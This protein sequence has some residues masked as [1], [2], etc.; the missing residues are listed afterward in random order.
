MPLTIVGQPHEADGSGYYRF[1]L[2]FKHLA[3]SS[4]HRVL[5]PEPGTKFTPSD[6]EIAQTDLIVGQRFCG[7]HG[8][9]LWERWRGRVKLVYEI[10]DHMMAPDPA[11]GLP[12]LFDATVRDSFKVNLAASDLVTVSTPVLA[13]V[14]GRYNPNVVVLPNFIDSDL[15]YLDR[16]RRDR[17]TVGWAGGQSHLLDWAHVM[18]P[19]GEVL[20]AN[21]QVD[22][23]FV[24][25][26]YS[27][28]LE[29]GREVRYT[30]WHPDVWDYFK[31]IDFDIGLC[32]LAS[33]PFNDCKSH[34]KAL[35]Y[36]ALGVPVIASDRPAYRDLVVDGVTGWLVR[37]EDEWRERL[38]DLIHDEAMRTEMGT[39]GREIARD[40]TIQQGWKLWRD[41]YEAVAATGSAP[42]TSPTKPKVTTQ[43]EANVAA[44]RQA[45]EHY[46]AGDRPQYR[47]IDLMQFQSDL[48]RYAEV[49]DEFQPPFVIEIG[50][51]KG[52]TALFLADLV[53]AY[54][55]QVISVDIMGPTPEHPNVTYIEGSSTSPVVRNEIDRLTD[56]RG[57]V[58]LDGDHS[59]RQVRAELDI[60]ADMADYL[61]VED[62][63]VGH[64]GW[65]DGPH[66]ALADWLGDHPEFVVDPDPSPTQHPGGW[67]RRI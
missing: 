47:G 18:H 54:G 4:D 27:P 28:V 55:G 13:E 29:L 32:P 33:S 44:W 61:I 41:A 43:S 57:L 31:G 40:W 34:I 42:A 30:P 64:L 10:D 11:Q 22:V 23:H 38:S 63:V 48:D 3:R 67:L 9:A 56:G 25:L 20:R 36:M 26:D 37:N 39:K 1:Y 66:T 12:Q 45:F 7:P 24:G 6:D 62:T 21:P 52:G 2:P 49:L 5:L 60:Y 16:P 46:P 14:M 19:I 65:T 58:L 35:E 15:L 50:R 59:G 8:V 17:I 51:S 53:A